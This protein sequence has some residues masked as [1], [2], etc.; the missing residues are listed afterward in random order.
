MAS[1]ARLRRLLV[2]TLRD[3]G[4]LTEQRWIDIF[5]TVPRHTFLPRFFVPEEHGWGTMARGDDGWLT[6]AYSTN[7]LATQLDDDSSRWEAA[8]PGGPL[9]GTPTSSSSMPAIMAIMLEEL[10]VSEG[11][12]ILEIG[13]GTGYNAALLCQR[14]GESNVT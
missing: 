14:L 13:T 6:R 12:R 11:Q 10:L 7:V 9:Q 8:R 4:A 1:A 5:R 2:A 3:E